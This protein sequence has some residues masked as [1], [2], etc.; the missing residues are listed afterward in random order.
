MTINQLYRQQ[1][2]V[3]ALSKCL[4]LLCFCWLVGSGFAFNET[5]LEV[6]KK[7]AL[8]YPELN[9]LGDNPC[10]YEGI[11][12]Q[13]GRVVSLDIA[14]RDLK[15]KGLPDEIFELDNLQMLIVRHCNLNNISDN[16][17]K[18]I[19]LKI[20]DVSENQLKTLPESVYELKALTILLAQENQFS[21][22]NPKLKNLTEL[23]TLNYSKNK[24]KSVP[25]FIASFNKLENLYFENNVIDEVKAD[26]SKLPALSELSIQN[27]LLKDKELSKLKQLSCTLS[28]T[29]QL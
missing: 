3:L 5:D 13:N 21:E 11:K 22:L 24:L 1:N 4:C 25:E 15:D 14:H 9:W 8:K 17:V 19:K 16:I 18:L 26:L 20:L 28:I 10:Q 6:L 2:Q 27:N 23:N 7:I 29:P 12:C